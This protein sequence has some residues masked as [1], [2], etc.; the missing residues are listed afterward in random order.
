MSGGVNVEEVE[1]H[2]G[3]VGSARAEEIKALEE[4]LKQTTDELDREGI[5]E[6]IR[7][8]REQDRV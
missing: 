6:R 2:F 5:V 1:K 7:L 8:L 4:L 3:F